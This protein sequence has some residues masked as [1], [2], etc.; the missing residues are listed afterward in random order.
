LRLLHDTGAARPAYVPEMKPTAHRS[1]AVAWS[2]DGDIVSGR[3]E[4]RGDG[5]ELC[6]RDRGRSIP[7]S[8]LTDA[9]IARGKRD[10][11]YGL[12]VLALGLCG[13]SPLRIASLE[14]VG[15]LHELAALIGGAV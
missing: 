2:S 9:A 14:G 5:F 7:F 8:Q 11:L 15:A 6:G 4:L 13:A 3:L 12:P 10:R 1:Y